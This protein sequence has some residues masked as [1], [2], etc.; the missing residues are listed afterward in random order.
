MPLKAYEDASAFKLFMVD[1]GLLGA[2]SGLDKKTLLSGN[3]IFTEFKG[4]LT[5]QFVMQQLK[6][7]DD[8]NIFYWSA[9]RSTAEVDFVVQHSGKVVPIEVKAAE[10]LQAKSLKVYFGKFQ[11]EVCIRISM[12]DYRKGDWLTNV[13]LYAIRQIPELL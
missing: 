12:S 5:E 7:V 8:M 6:G 4:A 11:P 3:Q 10:N 2:M 1:V 9:E 13:P